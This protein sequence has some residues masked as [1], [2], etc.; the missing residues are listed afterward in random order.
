MTDY[1]SCQPFFRSRKSSREKDKRFFF[2]FLFLLFVFILA[3]NFLC[4]SWF[5]FSFSFLF[6]LS[7][8]PD[9]HIWV[10]EPSHSPALEWKS[11]FTETSLH[12]AD[13]FSSF[14]QLLIWDPIY[15]S[16][17]RFLAGLLNRLVPGL[18]G[19]WRNLPVSCWDSFFLPCTIW[20]RLHQECLF[21]CPVPG[22]SPG[23]RPSSARVVIVSSWR[24]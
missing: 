8:L 2:F 18:L 11:V 7:C 6:F 14:S 12:F 9:V 10:A 19:S 4:Y 5:W 20:T 3:P 22:R 21:V 1:F 15:R 24:V 23:V 16:W 17:Q 13:G